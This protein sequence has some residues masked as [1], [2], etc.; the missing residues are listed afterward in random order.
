MEVAEAWLV[1][2]ISLVA[3]CFPRVEGA[4]LKRPTLGGRQTVMVTLQAPGLP[5]PAAENR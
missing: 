5:P 2:Q 4:A 3:C 1:A